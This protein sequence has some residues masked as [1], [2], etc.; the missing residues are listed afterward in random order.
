[1]SD[2][3]Q[4]QIT[5]FLAAMVKHEASDLYL[6]TGARASIKVMGGFKHLTKESLKPGL[7]AALAKG[8]MSDVE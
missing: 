6:T 8:M 5:A 7:V 2:P 4:L 1:M 3:N